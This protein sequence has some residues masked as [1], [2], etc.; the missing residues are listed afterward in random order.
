MTQRRV[1]PE[2][3]DM[4]L[5]GSLRAYLNGHVTANHLRRILN[6][7]LRGNSTRLSF[8]VVDLLPQFDQLLQLLQSGKSNTTAQKQIISNLIQELQNGL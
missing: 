8:T 2:E 7:E 6:S 3:I 1:S 5:V 4:H